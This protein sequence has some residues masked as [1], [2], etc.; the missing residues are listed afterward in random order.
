MGGMSTTTAATELRRTIRAIAASAV[1]GAVLLAGGG[2]ADAHARKHREC[3]AVTRG[4]MRAD[5]LQARH[6]KICLFGRGG[7]DH[8]RADSKRDH[9]YGG[10]GGDIL[11]ARNSS[12]D[13][14]ACGHGRDTA[15]VDKHDIVRNCEQVKLASVN[16]T[17]P[18]DDPPPTD[19]PPG[20]PGSSDCGFDASTI[21]APGCAVL[22]SDTASASDPTAGL[23]GNIE[24]AKTSRASYDTSGGDTNPT[25]DGQSQDNAD[26]RHLTALDGDD[27]WGERCEL[28]RNTR[29]YGQDQG[30]ETDGTFALYHEGEHATTFFSERYPSNF[31][32]STNHWQTIMQM[33]QTQPY[34]NPRADGPVIEL[35]LYGNQLRFQNH[36]RQMWTAPAPASDTWIRYAVNVVYSTDPALGS[37][38]INVDLNG[39]GD[40]LDANEQS[41]VIHLATL[42]AEAGAGGNGLQPG[43]PIPDHLRIG[44]YHDPAIPCP[45]PTG[46]SVDVDNVQVVRD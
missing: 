1:L 45:P 23:W 3:S 18:T 36:W 41:P 19:P 9:L 42:D 16:D 37:V 22:R 10:R 39:D 20:D 14:V 6:V 27:F 33:K 29:M 30:S 21:T 32:M 31:S 15:I 40:T 2:S 11:R 8:L 24:C 38:Q 44:L 28:G 25:A 46:C 34:T 43:D 13:L 5:S 4:T 17:P 7:N 26:Y 12:R 35:Q